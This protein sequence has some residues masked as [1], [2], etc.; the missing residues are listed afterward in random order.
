LCTIRSGEVWADGDWA[1]LACGAPAIAII[2]A[3]PP[4]AKTLRLDMLKASSS[5]IHT[6]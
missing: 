5:S 4:A 1:R 2:A 6:S 3:L